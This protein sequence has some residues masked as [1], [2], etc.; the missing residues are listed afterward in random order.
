MVADALTKAM[1]AGALLAF[2]WAHKRS[3]G[4]WQPRA[5]ML[6]SVLFTC[7]GKIKGQPTHTP[8]DDV[9]VSPRHDYRVR[10]LRD[11]LDVHEAEQHA[12]HRGARRRGEGNGRAP[13]LGRCRM[14]GR[15]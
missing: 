10:H 4:A 8:P 15:R 3:Y 9:H 7:L 2:F 12:R 14:L 5:A 6:A 1:K 13:R 11:A